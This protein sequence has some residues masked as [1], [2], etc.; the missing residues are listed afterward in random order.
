MNKKLPPH[1]T[2]TSLLFG[3]KDLTNLD[4]KTLGLK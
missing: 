2:H 3:Q 1:A 4:P